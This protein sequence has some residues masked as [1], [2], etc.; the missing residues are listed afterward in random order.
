MP[1][2]LTRISQWTLRS[3]LAVLTIAVCCLLL[4]S[5]YGD[6]VS[7][8]TTVIPSF[9]GLAI[10]FVVL[11][12]L[13]WAVVLLLLR[14][15]RCLGALAVT[16]LIVALPV[17]RSC[18]LNMRGPIQPLT[19]TSDGQ[20]ASHVDSL[21]VMS[22]NTRQMGAAHLA[23]IK[24]KLPVMDLVRSSG[25]DIVCLQEYSFAIGTSG[26]TEAELCEELRDIYPYYRYMSNES[27]RH[28]NLGIA[29]FS[30]YPIVEAV[31]IDKRQKGYFSAM[32]YQLQLGSRQIGL[33]NM[34]L[35]SNKLA[36]DDRILYDEM[37][38]HFESDSLDRI[39]SGMMH[40]LACAWRLRAYEA[41][42]IRQFLLDHHPK[43]MPLLVCGDMNDTPVSYC[44]RRLR[45]VGLTDTWQETGFGPGI[46]YREH[47]FWF[48]ID[49]LLH[50]PQLRALSMHVRRDV[51]F[52]DHYPIEATYQLL[53]E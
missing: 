19:E 30:K 10:G 29:C 11:L 31:P 48:R 13:A 27:S 32:Y 5:A 49:H 42:V 15:W 12:S 45:S 2:L 20:A 6:V 46:T 25:A 38:E 14:S 21:R 43:E 50:S 18:P 53:P 9:L 40:S 16:W 24:E 4:C 35:Q 8:A 41:N 52:S 36:K 47:H 22:F 7:P 28:H 39:R 26:H 37:I 1:H 23:R 44:A 3:V 17:W 33:V 34:H 51:T